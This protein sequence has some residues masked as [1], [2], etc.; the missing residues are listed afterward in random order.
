MNCII[1]GVERN[2]NQVQ[3]YIEYSGGVNQNVG[4]ILEGA[5]ADR[6][7]RKVQQIVG[8]KQIA[9]IAS[10]D[11]DIAEIPEVETPDELLG[12]YGGDAVKMAIEIEQSYA[13]Q[14][15]N[16]YGM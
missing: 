13:N 10:G 3:T 5:R 2:I 9:E 14:A 7:V 11:R 1:G 6:L 8:S 12:I 16:M 15:M 4:E